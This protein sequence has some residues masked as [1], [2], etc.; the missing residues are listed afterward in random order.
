[1]IGC[2]RQMF[3]SITRQKLLEFS[4]VK[5]VP[6]SVT[7]VSGRPNCANRVLSSLVTAVAVAGAA[8][9]A[10]IHLECVSMRTKYMFP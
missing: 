1:M 3:E 2:R 9:K 8:L 7:I 4:T 5:H 6:L 10:S